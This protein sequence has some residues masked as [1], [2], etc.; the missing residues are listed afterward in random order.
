[1]P[2]NRLISHYLILH[3]HDILV[4]ELLQVTELNMLFCHAS[5]DMLASTC[6]CSNQLKQ[7]NSH[8]LLVKSWKTNLNTIC[9]INYAYVSK[10]TRYNSD[11]LWR[12]L[13]ERSPRMRMESNRV[14]KSKLVNKCV[15]FLLVLRYLNTTP[16]R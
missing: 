16:F 11:E 7:T 15:N 8:I 2:I 12:S 1:M 3:E 9:V 13:L 4:L 6:I 5:R 10:F 14:Q